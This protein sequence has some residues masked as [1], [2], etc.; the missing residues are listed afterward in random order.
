MD[1]TSSI[2]VIDS[3]FS[4]TF[5]DACKLLAGRWIQTTQALFN[6]LLALPNLPKNASLVTA[7]IAFLPLSSSILAFSYVCNILIPQNGLR[8]KI[9]SSPRF[10]PKT[11]LVTGVGTAKGLRIARAFYET[12]HRVIG[13]DFQP[14]GI[15]AFRK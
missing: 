7:S 5:Q 13:A 4:P 9:R 14:F 8:G 2:L 6:L 11:I 15:P 10:R 12:G 3:D 1:G